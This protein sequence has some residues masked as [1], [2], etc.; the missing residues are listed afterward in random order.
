MKEANVTE[1]EG[2]P[3]D[4]QQAL[5]IVPDAGAVGA[6]MPPEQIQ[7]PP[8]TAAQAKVDAIANLTMK[9]YERAGTL[10]LTPDEVTKL[11]AEFPDEAFKPGAAGKEQLIYIEHAYLRD[12]L[13][14]VIGPCQWSI[15]PRNRWAE[16]FV[17]P[18]R[19][20]KAAVNGTRVYVEAMLI[21]RGAFCAEAVGDMDYYPSNN[22]QNYGDAVEGAKTAALRRCCKEIGIGLQAWKKDW[23]EGWWRRRTGKGD[24]ARGNQFQRAQG[25]AKPPAT[26]AAQ[27]TGKAP[28]PK[29]EGPPIPAETHRN[30]LI[31]KIGKGREVAEA[32]F[33][34]I[35][36]NPWMMPNEKLEDLCLRFVPTT[37]KRVQALFDAMQVYAATLK[38]ER[39][40]E[41]D[42]RA[43]D[44]PP[45]SAKSAKE[46]AAAKPKTKEGAA[47]DPRNDPEWF[48][49]I[50]CPIPHKGQKRDDYLANP[51][52][53][54][55]LYS[56]TKAGDEEAQKRLWGFAN[57]W[58]P[59]AREYNGKTYQPTKADYQFRDALDAFL[60]WH[61]KHGKDTEVQS[62][63]L[64]DPPTGAPP[65]D[66]D[67]ELP[68]E[69]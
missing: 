8:V 40:Y 31:G 46:T 60:E 29:A 33:K 6:A 66:E 17:I 11:Q 16:E 39:P 56:A 2:A 14:Q 59:E 42:T 9:A 37:V 38:A 34:N 15:V 30:W 10:V 19:P 20:G 22:Q 18:A 5:A 26:T 51:D 48:W 35:E 4:D 69:A 27:A 21:I 1:I 7:K 45:A 65:D 57:N 12:R 47:P 50:I 52:T 24:P 58:M 61:E 44:G 54:K 13:N 68:F 62:K 25:A 3:V 23:C 32:Y 43:N 36:P 28:P 41:P 53:I 64:Q 55:S 67:D 49:D 63:T